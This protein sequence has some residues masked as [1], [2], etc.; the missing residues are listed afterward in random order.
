VAAIHAV[1]P[2]AEVTH[3][4]DGLPF[5]DGQVDTELRQTLGEIPDTPLTVGVEKTIRH[6]QAALQDGRLPR[7]T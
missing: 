7:S 4:S 1:L 3:E 2:D 6:F 5:P